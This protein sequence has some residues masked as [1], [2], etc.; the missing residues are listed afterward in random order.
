MNTP[1]LARALER[2]MAKEPD[3]WNRK[4]LL[5]TKISV[6]SAFS[7]DDQ[8]NRKDRIRDRAQIRI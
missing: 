3:R 5:D 1:N 8:F 6:G 4:K 2:A 7:V